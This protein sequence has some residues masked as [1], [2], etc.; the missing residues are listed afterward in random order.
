[1]I[2]QEIQEH[3]NSAKLLLNQTDEIESICKLCFQAIENNKKIILC[4]N[5]GS[6]SD[7]IHIAAE[8]V[9][10]FEKERKGLPA[11]A[12][13]ANQSNIT[14]IG[15]DYGFENIFA[16]Q[17]E[18][19]GQQ[20]DILIGL[21]TSG[22]SKNIVQAINMAQSMKI[23]VIALT[24]INGGEVSQLNALTLKI[25]TNTTSRIQEMHILVGHIICKYI[26]SQI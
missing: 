2:S 26:E 15:N 12:L 20:G 10:K 18:A 14:S 5:G 4:G 3:I 24:G 9:G 17:I 6:A 13:S 25:Q 23:D 7:S 22:N 11:I 8:L 19:I 21:S 16:R 1:M